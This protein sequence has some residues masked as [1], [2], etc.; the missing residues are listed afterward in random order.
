[1]YSETKQRINAAVYTN[2]EGKV[3]AHNL[4]YVLHDIC[5]VTDENKQDNLVSGKN[6]KTVNG[7]SIVGPG[8]ISLPVDNIMSATSSNP[9]Q[10]SVVKEYIDSMEDKNKGYYSSEDVLTQQHPN[11]KFGSRAYVGT[12]YPYNIYVYENRWVDSGETGGDETVPLGEY[13]T[14]NVIDA[15]FINKEQIKEY[16]TTEEINQMFNQSFEVLT[17]EEYERLERKEN[18]L[19]FC[20]GYGQREDYIDDKLDPESENAVA[21]K[22][23]AEALIWEKRNP[24]E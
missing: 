17:V 4:N 23:V 21:N 12:S 8:N 3:T 22:V 5:D 13:Y 16:S 20:I 7:I 24:D 2:N 1:M 6:I 11:P 19:Y 15:N 10:N 9:V 18:K 14:K